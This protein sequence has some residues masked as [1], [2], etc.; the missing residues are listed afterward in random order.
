MKRLS[1]VAQAGD[2]LREAISNPR[3]VTLNRVGDTVFVSFVARQPRGHT[4]AAQFSGLDAEAKAK[5]WVEQRA[6]Y[7]LVSL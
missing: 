5:R 1:Q 7:K 3:L 6:A 2:N 4:S